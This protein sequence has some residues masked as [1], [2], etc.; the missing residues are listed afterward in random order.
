MAR[1]WASSPPVTK[2]NGTLGNWDSS[3]WNSSIPNMGRELMWHWFSRWILGPPKPSH[4]P[5]PLAYTWEC[6]SQRGQT[7][8]A[9]RA[10]LPPFT[11]SLLGRPCPAQHHFLSQSNA[12]TSFL[13]FHSY[14]KNDKVSAMRMPLKI[15]NTQKEFSGWGMISILYQAHSA[16]STGATNACKCTTHSSCS[17]SVK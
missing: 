14:R 3:P 16:P 9:T 8:E 7:D 4:G 10:R 15:R 5:H 17:W 13:Y 1:A 11:F 2:G 6:L 12:S